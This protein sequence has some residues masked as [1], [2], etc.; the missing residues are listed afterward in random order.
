MLKTTL[1]KNTLVAVF[2]LGLTACANTDGIEANVAE[3]SNKVK[4]LSAN[5][6]ELKTQQQV[7]NEEAKAAKVAAEQAAIDAKKANERVDNMVAS[8]KK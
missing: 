2:A 3:L 6:A 5:V 7:A 8:Y 4:A 1:I